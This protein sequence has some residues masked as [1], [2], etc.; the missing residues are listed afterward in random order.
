[1]RIVSVIEAGTDADVIERVALGALACSDVVLAICHPARDRTRGILVDLNRRGLPLIVF[2]HPSPLNTRPQ[3]IDMCRNARRF[4]DPDALLFLSRRELLDCESR[5]TLERSLSSLADFRGSAPGWD[6][7]SR[8]RGVHAGERILL[9]ADLE[10]LDGLAAEGRGRVTR[11]EA[12]DAAIRA[13]PLSRSAAALE[14]LRWLW[15]RN[16]RSVL[17]EEETIKRLIQL[18]R[19]SSGGGSLDT[20][21]TTLS[22]GSGALGLNFHLA[23]LYV[24][25]PPFRYVSDKFRPASVLDIGC[26]LGAYLALFR[27]RGAREVLGVDGFEGSD[28]GLCPEGYLRHDLRKPLDLGRTFDLVVCTEVI[29]HIGPD[30]EACVLQTIAR[31]A[32]GAILF[33]AARPGQPGVGHVNCRPIEH[34]MEFWRKAGWATQVFDTLAVRSLSTFFWFR[35]NLLVLRP[36]RVSPPE[37]FA[38][39]DLRSYEAEAIQWFAQPPAV[40]AYPLMCPPASTRAVSH[41]G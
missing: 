23:N 18:G 17:P 9:R 29:E 7:R 27:A 14:A 8:R 19:R 21:G 3:A 39:D 20:T 40:H 4:F 15:G 35:R 37:H 6:T 22:D 24:D 36:E 12:T 38:F 10:A 28:E 26:G 31:H 25:Y 33:S 16:R 41:A 5:R 34:W 11:T 1:M 13:V 32:G 2:D 30:F